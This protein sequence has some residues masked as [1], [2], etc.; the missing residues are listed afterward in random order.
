M[1]ENPDEQNVRVKRAKWLLAGALAVVLAVVLIVQFRGSENPAA[2]GSGET[3]TAPQGDTAASPPRTDGSRRP[4]HRSDTPWPTYPLATVLQFDPFGRP[5][6]LEPDQSSHEAAAAAKSQEI[7]ARRSEN[8]RAKQS[9]RARAMAE[10]RQ[11]TVRAIIG[12]DKGFVAVVGTKTIHVGDQLL[13]FRVT[14]IR[15]DGVIV[16]APATSVNP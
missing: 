5:A 9:E 15:P 3:S 4:R 13:G 6:S 10:V 12:T 8:A 1:S 7:A 16:E 11:Q 2:T 14:A